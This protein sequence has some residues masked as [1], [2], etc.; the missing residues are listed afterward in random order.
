MKQLFILLLIFLLSCNNT[1]T[2]NLAEASETTISVNNVGIT[3]SSQVL[4]KQVFQKQI[5]ANGKVA[6]Q[7]KSELRFKTTERIANIKVKNGQKVHKGQLLATLDNDLLANKLDKTK[8]DVAKANS[9]LQEEKINYSISD[10]ITISI[11]KELHIKSGY[12]E[13]QNELENAQLL[14]NQT[15]LKAPFSGVVANIET[16]TG[17]YITGS[18]IFCT[19]IDQQQQDVVFSVLENEMSFIENKQ[20]LE[21]TSFVDSDKKYIGSITEINP[22]VDDN[23]LIQIKATIKNSDNFLFDGMHV[24]IVINKPL[25]NVIVIPK[26][27]LVLRSNKEVVFTIEDGL[28]KWNYVEVRDENSTSYAIKKGLKLRDTIIISG[29]MNLSH[30]AKVNTSFLKENNHSK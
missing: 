30:D 10:T 16:K 13:A 6:A 11:L 20:A 1:N 24:K 23:G 22:L 4:E 28:A 9:K 7:Q 3:V 14:F 26:E 2:A 21:I 29:N 5:I 27:A 15:I 12:L 17:N 19:L 25:T 8:L 18:D